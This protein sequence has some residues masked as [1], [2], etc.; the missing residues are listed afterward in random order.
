[1]VIQC[2]CDCNCSDSRDN[3]SLIS[4]CLP[5]ATV[6]AARQQQRAGGHHPYGSLAAATAAAASGGDDMEHR[7]PYY[8]RLSNTSSAL[9]GS[10]PQLLPTATATATATQPCP[11]HLEGHAEDRQYSSLVRPKHRSP[12]LCNKCAL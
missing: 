5:A 9:Y 11:H 6:P 2:T 12:V 3:R 4:S 8:R 7:I 1:M 10:C